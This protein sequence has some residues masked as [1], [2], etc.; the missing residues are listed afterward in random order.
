MNGFAILRCRSRLC[1]RSC[2]R[3]CCVKAGAGSTGKF[4]AGVCDNIRTSVQTVVVLTAFESALAFASAV[5]DVSTPCVVWADDARF[6]FLRSSRS[7]CLTRSPNCSGSCFPETLDRLASQNY[8]L[9]ALFGKVFTWMLLAFFNDLHAHKRA[10]T[11]VLTQC[12]L[13]SL[14]SP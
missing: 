1:S 3:R 10:H 9:D 12:V 14:L 2:S 5:E 4:L 8:N 13:K 6:L 11:P 7:F